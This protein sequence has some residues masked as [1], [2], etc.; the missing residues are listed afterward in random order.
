M[1]DSDTLEQNKQAKAILKMLKELRLEVISR[2]GLVPRRSY[3]GHSST[4]DLIWEV[5][6]Q[7]LMENII[8]IIRGDYDDLDKALQE[9]KDNFVSKFM[10]LHHEHIVKPSKYNWNWD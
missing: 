8:N 2:S 3:V 9:Y 5:T 10:A 1:V 7:E 6:S 4:F